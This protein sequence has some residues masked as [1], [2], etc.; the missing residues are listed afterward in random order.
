[1]SDSA[2]KVSLR[3]TRPVIS[4]SIPGFPFLQAP[5]PARAS[6][7]T[8]SENK[9]S[10][11]LTVT[12]LSNM[13]VP[14]LGNPARPVGWRNDLPSICPSAACRAVIGL[15][16][17]SLRPARLSS[18]EGVAKAGPNCGGIRGLSRKSGDYA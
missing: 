4:I 1:M 11:A 12:K 8:K 7:K 15:T 9:V 14:L 18:P 17:G 6:M 13:V 3:K 5:A 2:A 10:R 16:L